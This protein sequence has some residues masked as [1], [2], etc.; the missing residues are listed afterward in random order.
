[1]NIFFKYFLPLCLNKRQF[2]EV[3]LSG[4][5]N[6]NLVA[7][8]G[9]LLD[10]RECIYHVVWMRKQRS[11]GQALVHTTNTLQEKEEGKIQ[12]V[13]E[14]EEE[15]RKRRK[16]NQNCFSNTHF[17][18]VPFSPYMFGIAGSLQ[19]QLLTTF[20]GSLLNINGYYIQR[21]YF[22]WQVNN[23]KNDFP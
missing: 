8:S 10:S 18:Q 7:V 15:R 19:N 1:M 22:A 13:R 17:C 4:Q 21:F 11:M 20:F 16:Q 5:K 23:F 6:A 14:E 12:K 9:T 2:I 3:N